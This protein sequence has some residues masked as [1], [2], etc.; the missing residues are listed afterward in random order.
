MECYGLTRTPHYGYWP[1]RQQH[2]SPRSAWQALLMQYFPVHE[3]FVVKPDSPVVHDSLAHGGQFEARGYD[4]LTVH[5]A[6][7]G[8]HLTLIAGQSAFKGTDWPMLM[9]LW[10]RNDARAPRFSFAGIVQGDKVQFYAHHPCHGIL[11]LGLRGSYEQTIFSTLT[12]GPRIR[13]ILAQFRGFARTPER[14]AETTL[15]TK[16]LEYNRRS[17]EEGWRAIARYF[18]PYRSGSI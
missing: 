1:Y 5:S 16:G 9:S 4:T 12:E 17:G 18:W 15:E 3:G 10:P 11:P 8:T 2:S 13:E 14:A 7:T 6:C